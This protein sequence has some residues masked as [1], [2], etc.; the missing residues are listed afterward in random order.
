MAKQGDIERKVDQVLASLDDIQR[1]PANP[2]L[3]TRIEQ[4]L[5]KGEE[6]SGMLAIFNRPAF[7]IS[8]LVLVILMNSVIFLRHSDNNTNASA[9]TVQDDEQLFAREYSYGVSTA[10]RF[11]SLNEVQP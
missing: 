6:K 7:M 4:T 9:N 11:Y 2:F 8:G 10:D 1:A 5:K 3:Y